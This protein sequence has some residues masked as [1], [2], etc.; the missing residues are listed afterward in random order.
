V[1]CHHAHEGNDVAVARE[2][3]VFVG[4]GRLQD[5]LEEGLLVV[6]RCYDRLVLRGR[7]AMPGGGAASSMAM[8][9]SSLMTW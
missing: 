7:S 4:L 3:L 5:L 1:L 8:P 2:D 6:A 9:A